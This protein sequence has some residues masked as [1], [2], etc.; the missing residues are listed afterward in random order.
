[1]SEISATVSAA[2]QHMANFKILKH[3]SIAV[4]CIS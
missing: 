3:Q 2:A 1:M 4:P